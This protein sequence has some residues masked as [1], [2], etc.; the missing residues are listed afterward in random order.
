MKNAVENQKS[1][2]NS[3]A[4]LLMEGV[5][6]FDKSFSRLHVKHHSLGGLEV[7]L[8]Y[9]PNQAFLDQLHPQAGWPVARVHSWRRLLQI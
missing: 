9:R 7:V 3:G 1:H 6:E 8:R 2:H 4:Q 5:G